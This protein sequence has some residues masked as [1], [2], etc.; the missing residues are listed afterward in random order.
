MDRS[1]LTAKISGNNIAH[2]RWFILSEKLRGKGL[3]RVLLQKALDH[4]DSLGFDEIHLWTLKGLDAARSLYERNGFFLADEYLGDQW[5][6][7]VAEQKFI[8]KR[9]A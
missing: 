9:P 2:L 4:C 8:R 6:K 3:G 7:E 1:R 5:G